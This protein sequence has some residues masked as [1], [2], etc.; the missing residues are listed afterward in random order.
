M[1]AADVGGGGADAGV[2]DDTGAGGA[3]GPGAGG[4]GGAGAGGTG[5]GPDGADAGGGGGV[6]RGA[7][8]LAQ[9]VRGDLVESE[10]LGHL[11][12][13]GPDGAVV[14][15]IG[16][17]EA[18]IWPRSS[19]KPVQAVAML[20]AG[21]GEA[22]GR[23]EDA[24]GVDAARRS[25]ALACASHSG[26]DEHLAVVRATLAAAGLDEAALQNTPD[27]PLDESA[28]AA[29]RAA[30]RPP[31]SLA[32]NCS[33][34]HA[35]M[36]ATCVAAGWDPTSY[37]E[38]DHPLQVGVRAAVEELTGG[39]VEHVTVDGCGAPLL[40]TT[41]VG[42]ARAL[43][44]IAAAPRREPGTP[45]A[46]VARAMAEHPGLVGG[47]G[48]DVT[49]FMEAVPG[50]VAKDGAEGV[51][52]AGLPDGSAV[53]FKVADG[54]GRPRPAV[55]ARA[56]EDLVDRLPVVPAGVVAAVREV[57]RAPVLGHGRPVGEVRAVSAVGV[58]GAVG[59]RGAVGAAGVGDE[60]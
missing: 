33:G 49:R 50:L 11:V 53:A 22:L 15:S 23:L 21:L 25:L 1:T 3:G 17:P 59:V 12:L 4:T 56:L 52:A 27:L 43:G 7:G 58:M 55:L 60:R 41:V 37:R 30:G 29:W 18:V 5:T 8:L 13:V 39:P 26:T 57:G 20:R 45:E 31:S 40:S 2:T 14:A 47:P 54:S 16:D 38:V 10:H 24:D 44:R 6:A 48:R 46:A 32:Q 35:A 51:Y 42:L 34:K 28:A 9:V 36:L 19:L